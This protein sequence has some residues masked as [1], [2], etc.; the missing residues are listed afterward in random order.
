MPVLHLDD[1]TLPWDRRVRS[2]RA[3]VP[4]RQAQEP[5]RVL[6]RRIATFR[7]A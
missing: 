6:N 1:R 5:T 7:V 4:M 2:R 3:I